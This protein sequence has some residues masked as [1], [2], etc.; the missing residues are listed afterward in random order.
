[1]QNTD[2]DEPAAQLT[3]AQ[4]EAAWLDREAHLRSI[5]DTVPDAM[6]VIDEAGHIHSFP[7]PPNG[8]SATARRKSSAGM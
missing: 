5:L 3:A 4:T 6:I 8:C 2:S 1:M 7:P